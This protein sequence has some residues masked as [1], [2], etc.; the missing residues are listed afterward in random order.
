MRYIIW[1]AV[2]LVCL[3][4]NQQWGLLFNGEGPFRVD[5]IIDWE[6]LMSAALGAAFVLTAA[7]VLLDRFTDDRLR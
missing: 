6:R 2:V 1:P 5:G 4:L 7:D 3:L